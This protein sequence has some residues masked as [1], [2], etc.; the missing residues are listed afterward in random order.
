MTLALDALTIVPASYE[1]KILSR[2]LNF[3]EW[4][5]N[6]TLEQYLARDEYMETRDFASNGKM[7]TWYVY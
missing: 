5:R 7:T 3:Q 4:G 6:L 1:Q 2:K